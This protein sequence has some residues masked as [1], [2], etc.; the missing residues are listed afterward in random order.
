MEWAAKL[1]KPASKKRIDTHYINATNYWR[2][3][4]DIGYID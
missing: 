4:F 2:I 1:N 3:D